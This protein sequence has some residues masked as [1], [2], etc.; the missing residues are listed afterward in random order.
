MKPK[1]ANALG[2]LKA[3]DYRRAARIFIFVLPGFES[4]GLGFI[5]QARSYQRLMEFWGEIF[6]QDRTILPCSVGMMIRG[7]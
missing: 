2:G 3:S 7:L 5:R 1:I 4:N 6:N